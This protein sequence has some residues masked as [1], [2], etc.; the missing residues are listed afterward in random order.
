MLH[1]L[2]SNCEIAIIACIT[3]LRLFLVNSIEITHYQIHG[4]TYTSMSIL[5]TVN[6]N[7]THGLCLFKCTQERLCIGSKFE[8]TDFEN[9][10]TCK[11]IGHKALDAA[12]EQMD[13]DNTF[14][15]LNFQL[16][17]HGFIRILNSCYK[18]LT[19]DNTYAGMFIDVIIHYY[20]IYT[21]C[22]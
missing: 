17:P 6:N 2:P 12:T 18:F 4:D 13:I 8:G 11:L 1:E 20:G 22:S 16:C 9:S 15:K 7:Q 3:L 5:K 19:D 21:L 10:A 14:F